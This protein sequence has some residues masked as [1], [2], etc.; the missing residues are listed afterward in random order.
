M[1]SLQNKYLLAIG[2][3]LI[4]AITHDFVQDLSEARNLVLHPGGSPA[5]LCRFFQTCGGKAQL[6]A[7][8]GEDG[9]GKILIEEISK[10]GID[11]S[12]IQRLAGHATS[13]VVVGRSKATPDFIPYRDA[14]RF[15]QTVDESLIEGASVVHTTAFA[16]SKPPA[17]QT[18]LKAFEQAH[19]KGITVS[20]DWNYAEPIWGKDNIAERVLQEIMVYHPLLK[21]SMDDINRFTRSSMNI[22]S[23][24]EYL[25]SFTASVICLT[26]GA[27]GVWFKTRQIQW[28][29]LPAAKVKVVD[30]TGAGD[31]FWA[32]FLIYHMK[33]LP[34]ES[35]I[36]N[37]IDTAAKRLEG[38]L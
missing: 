25:Q 29:H 1:A 4:D 2:E 18:I 13:M 37:G 20:I 9:L 32:G 14:D 17:Q 16:L 31:A 27:D 36:Q 15:L 7:A 22:E 19:S 10:A 28:Q 23:A 24:K 8:V 33:K 11:T 12:Y 6:S 34:L 3:S 5:N 21:I 26:C 38:K 35:S 30:T